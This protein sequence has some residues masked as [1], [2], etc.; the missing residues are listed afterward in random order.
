MSVLHG[1]SMVYIDTLG[2]NPAALL[3]INP[4]SIREERNKCLLE[5]GTLLQ[6]D[7]ISLYA[8][9]VEICNEEHRLTIGGF[10]IAKQA[11]SDADPGFA[12]EAPTTKLNAMRVLRAL[13]VQKPILIE[14]SPGVGKTTL[15][16][17][18]A[19]ACGKPLTRI[20]LSEQTDLMDLFGSDVPVEGAEAGHFAWRDAPFLQAMQKGEWV[21]LDEM[22]LASQSVLEGL[23]ACLDHRGEVYISELGQTFKRHPNFSVFAAQNPHHQGGGRKGLPASFVNRFTVV[24]ADVFRPEDLQLIWQAQFSFHVRCRNQ[25]HHTICVS[26]WSTRQFV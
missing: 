9:P 15:I 7:V 23:N 2:A 26:A 25:H 17:A 18:L 20:N 21:L 11:G 10:S 1:A 4:E 16:A 8:E 24:Y 14:G 13:Q 5:L 6:H 22:N 19:R 12:F 3:A